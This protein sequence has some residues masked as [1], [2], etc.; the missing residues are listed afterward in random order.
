MQDIL[1]WRLYDRI[2]TDGD[3][4]ISLEEYRRWFSDFLAVLNY[5]GSEYITQDDDYNL[6]MG[7]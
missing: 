7:N 1:L 4:V 6:S 3:G 5:Y 2:D